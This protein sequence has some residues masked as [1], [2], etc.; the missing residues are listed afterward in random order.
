MASAIVSLALQLH[1]TPNVA[2]TGELTLT[3]KS[4]PVL[5][6]SFCNSAELRP[7]RRLAVKPLHT[8]FSSLAGKVLKVGGIKEKVIAAKRENVGVSERQ[9][10]V[11][12]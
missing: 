3:G 1:P 9:T 8:R 4:K 10:P 11:S 12:V 6:L 5:S 2:M 7:F